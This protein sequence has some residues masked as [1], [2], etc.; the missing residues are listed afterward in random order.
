MVSA[1]PGRH[2]AVVLQNIGGRLGGV[3]GLCCTNTIKVLFNTK[4]FLDRMNL[5]L[6]S[7]HVGI[8]AAPSLFCRATGGEVDHNNTQTL[9]DRLMLTENETSIHGAFLPRKQS[10][11]QRRVAHGP[12]L[13]QTQCGARRYIKRRATK[14]KMRIQQCRAAMSVQATE[15]KEFTQHHAL[16]EP[17]QTLPLRLAGRRPSSSSSQTCPRR[18]SARGKS[19]C[20]PPRGRRW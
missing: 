17:E 18:P 20:P 10:N 15:K 14:I 19:G 2:E 1:G 13:V 8:F 7:D 9:L 5:K 4:A 16:M 11:S 12:L 6:R 3:Y